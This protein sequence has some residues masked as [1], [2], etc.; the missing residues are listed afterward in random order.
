MVI[1]IKY[2]VNY[3]LFKKDL[4][5]FLIMVLQSRSAAYDFKIKQQIILNKRTNIYFNREGIFAKIL[6]HYLIINIIF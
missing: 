4:I 5:I 2:L 3:K 1:S 6:K